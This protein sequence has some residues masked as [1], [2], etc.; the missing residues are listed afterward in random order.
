[1]EVTLNGTSTRLTGRPNVLWLLMAPLLL[2]GC[3]SEGPLRPPT[4]RLPAA[5]HG[6]AAQR[7]GGA[8]DLHWI[9][10][11]R[12]TDGVSLTG[13]HGAGQLSAEI[14][15]A[16][17][18][19]PTGTCASFTK[20]PVQAGMQ[21]S[22][23]DLLPNELTSGPDRALHY[24]IRV[25]NERGKSDAFADVLTVAGEA[26][27]AMRGLNASPVAGGIQLRWQPGASPRDRTMLR[28]MRGDPP[29]AEFHTRPGTEAATVDGRTPATTLLAVEAS[30]GDPG[31]ALDAGGHSGVRQ[32]YAVYRSRPAHVAG[33]DLVINGESAEVTVAAAALP[34][35]PAAPTALEAVPNTLGS[36]SIDLVWQA[37]EEPGVGG[38]LVF[39]SEGTSAPAQL[40]PSPLRGFTYTD[41]SALPGIDYRYSVAAVSTDGRAG[42]HSQEIRA[43]IPRLQDQPGD[44]RKH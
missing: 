6:L 17:S 34:P 25:S 40:T 24:R 9:N 20:I 29:K 42:T 7:S 3:A 13:K 16:E 33:A 1:L 37:G 11:T 43:S 26:P 38:Y 21:A 32:S 22:F 31:G 41:A 35:P 36:P 44:G 8:V 15:R 28:V 12:T 14:C 23:H 18:F 30:S 2:T 39:R 5:V 19:P 4:L 27:A 10:P